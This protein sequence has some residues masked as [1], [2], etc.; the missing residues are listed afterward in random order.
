MKARTLLTML[1]PIDPLNPY[2]KVEAET[3]AWGRGLQTERLNP[4]GGERWNQRVTSIEQDE[5]ILVKGVDLL[6]YYFAS[7]SLLIYNKVYTL[8]RMCYGNTRGGVIP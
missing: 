4:W 5:F 7:S 2:R 6:I 8:Y 3:M 1:L